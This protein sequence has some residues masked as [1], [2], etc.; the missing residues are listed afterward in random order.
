MV[1][2]ES[3]GGQMHDRLEKCTR[4]ELARTAHEEA[5][6]EAEEVVHCVRMLSQLTN[7]LYLRVASGHYE[8]ESFFSEHLNKQ[9]H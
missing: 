7:V 9:S 3:C 2:I 1:D 4:H 8:P 5:M 6:R